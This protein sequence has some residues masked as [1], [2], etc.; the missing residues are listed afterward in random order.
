MCAHSLKRPRAGAPVRKSTRIL[1]THAA[2]E[3]HCACVCNG[4][5]DNVELKGMKNGI[6][7]SQV[8]T[9]VQ[10]EAGRRLRGDREREQ[11]C[12]SSGVGARWQ[13]RTR[14]RAHGR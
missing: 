10:Q 14:G 5:H 11:P 2:F 1:A 8:Y 7:W 4:G 12:T 13:R 9:D 6:S 3:K